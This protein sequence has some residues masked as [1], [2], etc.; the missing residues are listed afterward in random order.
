MASADKLYPRMT[1]EEQKR[2]VRKEKPGLTEAEV[3][4]EA[5]RRVGRDERIET[6][7]DT[8]REHRQGSSFRDAAASAEEKRR[9]RSLINGGR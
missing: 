5:A 3:T 1:L 4:A 9:R 7:R 8:N 2:R 6:M